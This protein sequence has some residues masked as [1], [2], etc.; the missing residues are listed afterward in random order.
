MTSKYSLTIGEGVTINLN[1][2]TTNGDKTGLIQI[3]KGGIFISDTINIKVNFNNYQDNYIN[4]ISFQEVQNSSSTP[5]FNKLL[6]G[7]LY[8]SY[9]NSNNVDTTVTCTYISGNFDDYNSYDNQ[10]L[11]CPPSSV[12]STIVIQNTKLEQNI[13]F[14]GEMRKTTDTYKMV[15]FNEENQCLLFYPNLKDGSCHLCKNDSYLSSGNCEVISSKC[16]TLYKKQTSDVCEACETGSEVDKYQCLPCPTNC[17]HCAKGKCVLCDKEYIVDVNR[18]CEKVLVYD[19][20]SLLIISGKTIK[21]NIGYFIKSNK[22]ENCGENCIN[23]NNESSCKICDSKSLLKNGVCTLQNRVILSNNNNLI[24]CENGY[25]NIENTCQSCSNKYGELC[26]L[27]DTHNCLKCTLNGVINNEGKC[28]ELIQSSCIQ[29]SNSFC[30]GC[31]QVSNFINDSGVCT[32]N[33]NCLFSN[34]NEK[35]LLCENNTFYDNTS[36]CVSLTNQEENCDR[37]NKEQDRCIHC[38]TGYFVSNYH[39]ENCSENC[40]DCLD[41][42]TCL[43]CT[44]N[45]FLK[46]GKCFSNSEVITNCKKLLPS[47]SICAFCESHFFRNAEGECK[48]CI[49]NCNECNTEKTCL[50]CF[51]NYFLLTN[52]TQCISYDLLVNCEFKSQSGC[53]KCSTGFYQQNQ[54]CVSCNSTT[55][56]CSTCGTTGICTSCVEDY[57][58]IDS[59]CYS[60]SSIENCVEVTNSKCTKCTFWHTPNYSNTSCHTKVVWWVILIGVIFVLII[61][62]IVVSFVLFFSVK[63]SHHYQTKKVYE[64]MCIFDVRKSNI[65]FTETSIANVFV[66]K[67]EIE[68]EGKNDEEAI[69]VDR[70][71]RELFCVGN[72][73]KNTIKVQFSSKEDTEKYSIRT[74]PLVITL[75]KNKAIEFEIFIQPKCSCKIEDKIT[76]FS[77]DFKSGITAETPI[78]LVAITQISTKLDYEELNEDK[79]LGEGGFGIVYKGTFRGNFVAIKKMKLTILDDQNKEFENEVS[80]LDKFRNEYIVHFYGAVFIPNKMCMVTEFAEFGSLQDLMNH[81]ISEEVTM[82]LRLKIMLDAAK[83]ISYLHENGILHRDIKPDNILAFSLDVNEK[84]NAKLT[85]FGSARNV[86]LLMTNMTFTKGIGS[87]KYMAPE[88]LEQMKYKKSAD[89]YSFA[90]TMFECFGWKEA[91]PI[92]TFKYTWKIAEFVISGNRL[93]KRQETPT[94]CYEIIQSCWDQNPKERLQINGVVDRLQNCSDLF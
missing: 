3:Q 19:D 28:I 26:S 56:N 57:V 94:E 40:L 50:S 92:D 55:F 83:G 46:Y 20:N 35:C 23:C 65:R 22:C 54:F 90:I 64:N 9:L 60:K 88:V 47:K 81:K 79:K 18:N 15:S 29:T 61:L 2:M 42:S 1:N 51:T 63:I 68:F 62:T 85:D 71:S 14:I 69:P 75:K 78:N 8:R 10:V 93:K 86:N 89:I 25:Y 67:N 87:P 36:M 21:C 33:S 13:N 31:K 45:H 11:H 24:V 49:E 73:G 84:V 77:V 37:M 59:K 17:L 30:N 44:E 38:L 6:G 52:N 32:S 72:F 34:K 16:I 58:L 41:F 74:E 66:N 91:Y 80:M 53:L 48:N 12:N 27:W 5:L 4:L 39:C 82:K 43:S 70:E 76:L 7:K